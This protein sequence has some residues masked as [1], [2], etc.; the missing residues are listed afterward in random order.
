MIVDDFQNV[1][2]LDHAVSLLK[3]QSVRMNKID[4]ILSFPVLRKR[5][6]PSDAELYHHLNRIRGRDLIYA[7]M[8]LRGHLQSVLSL[9]SIGIRTKPFDPLVLVRDIQ[10][11]TSNNNLPLR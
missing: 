6:T 1:C 5:M 11:E 9:C 2:Y 7:L 10:P 4:R 3:N 8:D